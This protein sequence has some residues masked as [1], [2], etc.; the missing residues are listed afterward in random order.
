M[1]NQT[2][3]LLFS[4]I[5]DGDEKAFKKLF[6]EYYSSLC[7]FATQFLNDDS[8]AEGIVQEVF[9]KIWEK[10][11][12]IEINTSLK[13]YLFRSVRNSCLNI[14]QH[15]KV[16]KQYAEQV[17]GNSKQ[18]IDFSKYYLEVGLAQKIEES[19]N[20]LPQKRKEIFKL[21]KEDGLKYKEIADKLNISVKTVEVQM[22][23]AL[24][25]LREKLKNYQN[26]LALFYIFQK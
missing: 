12:V 1:D 16:K 14:I 26:L 7:Y 21:S 13:Q 25:T 8:V 4:K 10:K 5:R 15:D 11:K 22:G 23:L 20:S 2:S 6:Q 9:L 3:K 24:K 18:N 17:M 19:I